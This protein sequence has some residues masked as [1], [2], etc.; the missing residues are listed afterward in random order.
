MGIGCRVFLV[1]DNHDLQSAGAV[2]ISK[3]LQV[4]LLN[5]VDNKRI[6]NQFLFFKVS[7]I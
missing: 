7:E 2:Q 3:L 6:E 1:D 4:G 5:V